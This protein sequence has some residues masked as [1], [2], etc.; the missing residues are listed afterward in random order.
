[1]NA[2][3][4]IQ[5]LLAAAEAGHDSAIAELLNHYDTELRWIA[6]RFLGSPLQAHLDSG[7]LVQSVHRSML[8]GLRS[9]R[10]LINS[11]EQ[12]RA[13]VTAM[14]RHKIGRHWR[15]LQRQ[16][17]V[18]TA[19][20]E[21]G[22]NPA[23]TGE[24]AEVDCQEWLERWLP[25]LDEQERALVLGKLAGRT[26]VEVA[27]ALRVDPDILRVKLSRLRKRWSAAGLATELLS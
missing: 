20:G 7:D 25:H 26:T 5:E 8:Q 24:I 12:L 14:I 11:P 16:Q 19:E 9:K 18:G 15:R 2:P 1:M 3:G 13:L 6:R 10:F 23:V 21:C 17:R 4:N 22:L 27:R